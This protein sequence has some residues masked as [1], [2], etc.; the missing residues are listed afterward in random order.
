MALREEGGLALVQPVGRRSGRGAVQ[1]A[2]MA[3]DG[4]GEGMGTDIQRVLVD[5]A[6]GSAGRVQER[7]PEGIVGRFVPAVAAV[8]QNRDAV[9]A[10]FRGDVG[11]LLG[12]D[13][14]GDVRVV[15][16]P[17]E[18]QAE[19]ITG[20]RGAEGERK[21]GLQEG[22]LVLPVDVVLDIDPVVRGPVI[23]DD[24]LGEGGLLVAA[25]H[26]QDSHQRTG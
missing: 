10:V 7:E 5:V 23:E 17:D 12:G 19:V 9:A 25:V 11:P 26:P 16:A 2:R 13:L 22:A 18:A 1:R 3:H 20:L 21:T 24:P 8:A 14:I 6:L 4:I 15:S